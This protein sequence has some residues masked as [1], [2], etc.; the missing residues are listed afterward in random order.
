MR[1]IEKDIMFATAATPVLAVEVE[2]ARVMRNP[3][4]FGKWYA[5]REA[6][7]NMLDATLPLGG[8]SESLGA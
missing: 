3:A 6:A 8:R 7:L 5:A 1:A 4:S 2:R